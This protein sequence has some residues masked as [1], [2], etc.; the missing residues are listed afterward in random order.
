MIKCPQCGKNSNV[1]T[2]FCPECG[3]QISSLTIHCPKCRSQI[4]ASSEFCSECGCN[5]EIEKELSPARQQ[6]QKDYI[7]STAIDVGKNVVVSTAKGLG[8]ALGILIMM[9]FLGIALLL[10]S[11]S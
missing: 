2:K 11:L 9:F 10:S 3:T 4:A 1:G 6:A 8:C 7:K 5:I